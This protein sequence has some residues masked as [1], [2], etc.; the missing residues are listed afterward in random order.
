[1]VDKLSKNSLKLLIETEL[2]SFFQE[3]NE[4]DLSVDKLERERQDKLA[5]DIKSKK[6]NSETEKKEVDE[7]ETDDEQESPSREDRTGGKGTADSPKAK[8][9]KRKELENPSLEDFVDKLNV[10]RG[11]GSLSD[12][13]I[14]KA[15]KIYLGTLTTGEKQT[16][17]IF[18]TAISQI[19]VG[20]KKGADAIE[21]ADINLR[22]RKKEAESDPNPVEKS[23][24]K[25]GTE[26]TPIIVGEGQ[27]NKA[28]LS[29]LKKKGHLRES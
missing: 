13:D 17:L 12:Q 22:V 6:L 25:P 11:G 1:M 16:M 27:N 26:S 14:R 2:E 28:L 7:A 8:I 18:L 3:L 24:D 4:S 29:I 10:I 19:L 9:P 21:P 15:F 5:D 23:E 20:K